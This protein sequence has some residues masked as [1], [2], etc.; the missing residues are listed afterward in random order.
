[1][2]KEDITKIVSNRLEVTKKEIISN[3][4][5]TKS[6]A[7]G[8]T[9][10]SLRIELHE[11]G[12]SLLG[13]QAFQTVQ[14]G[15]KGGKAPYSF[16]EIIKQ[17]I[18]DKGISIKEI[19]YKRAGNHKFTPQERGLNTMSFLIARH[20]REKGSS[21]YNRGGRNDIYTNVID[22]QLPILKK[23]LGSLFKLD[24]KKI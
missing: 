4:K 23:E 6:V 16:Q 12:G 17:W 19:P 14:T 9:I 22:K 10:S 24:I 20:I 18:L 21:L 13:R 3:L 7:S 11:S 2:K 5:Q 8:K 15:R 1:M